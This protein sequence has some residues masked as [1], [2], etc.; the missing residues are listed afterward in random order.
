[1]LLGFVPIFFL[2]P[3]PY[4]NLPENVWLSTLLM[5]GVLA[6][7]LFG[8][9]YE[10][11]D[12]DVCIKIGPFRFGRVTINEIKTVERSYI[13]LSAPAASLKRILIQSDKRTLLISPAN[14][15][16]FIRK[17]K[18]SNPNIKVDIQDNYAWWKFWN[19]DI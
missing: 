19:W 10:I 11:N 8:I 3:K 17:L 14:E 16:E 9:R 4:I 15:E 1:L 7:L 6:F 18:S 5:V 2:E 13:I 12:K